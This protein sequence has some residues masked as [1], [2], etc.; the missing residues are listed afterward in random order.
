MTIRN[1]KS[2]LKQA[3]YHKNNEKVL[4]HLISFYF[5]DKSVSKLDCNLIELNYNKMIMDW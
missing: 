3:R 4:K 1:L 2:N 5:L